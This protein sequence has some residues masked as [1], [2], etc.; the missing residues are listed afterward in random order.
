MLCPYADVAG[1]GV[2]AAAEPSLRLLCF[3]PSAAVHDC[4]ANK[5]TVAAELA[6]TAEG[7]SDN[8]AAMSGKGPRKVAAFELAHDGIPF[9]QEYNY[10]VRCCIR[11]SPVAASHNDHVCNRKVARSRAGSKYR[12]D[13][14]AN[15]L[16]SSRL[17]RSF[18][19]GGLVSDLAD[20]AGVRSGDR[21]SLEMK[22]THAGN[23]NA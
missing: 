9:D 5:P 20:N 1:A 6:E 7:P 21:S 15:R 10:A 2:G 13:R 19:F 22:A 3:T 23:S 17:F 12:F 11:L 14:F 16:Y 8:T 18:L 4:K